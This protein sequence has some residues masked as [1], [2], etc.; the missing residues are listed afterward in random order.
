MRLL[1]NK[2]QKTIKVI[3]GQ[4]KTGASGITGKSRSL[5]LIDTNV[6]E[7]FSIIKN[8]LK[9]DEEKTK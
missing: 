8:A 3:V 2:K 5:T 7:V 6:E 9:K 1:D 4:S